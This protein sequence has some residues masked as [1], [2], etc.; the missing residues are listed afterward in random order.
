[1]LPQKT[2]TFDI[3]PNGKSIGDLGSTRESEAKAE[4]TAWHQIRKGVR[5]ELGDHIDQ[6][7]FAKAEVAECKETKTL[8]LTMPTRFMADW[9]RNNY[10]HVIRRVAGSVGM[11]SVE[12]TLNVKN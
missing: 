8:T 2:K 12:Y 10:Y 6:A 9:I 7:W 3:D 1:M 5:E 4:E 11:N